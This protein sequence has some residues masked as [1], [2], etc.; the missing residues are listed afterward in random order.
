ML[1]LPL[2]HDLYFILQLLLCG[3]PLCLNAFNDL[4]KIL[5]YQLQ[6]EIL[7]LLYPLHLLI[8]RSFILVTELHFV[9]NLLLHAGDELLNLVDLFL[10]CE[11]GGGLVRI[12]RQAE[13]PRH[14]FLHYFGLPA[15]QAV[16][17]CFVLLFIN[18]TGSNRRLFCLLDSLL[19]SSRGLL[20]TISLLALSLLLTHLQLIHIAVRF[21]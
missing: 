21:V 13:R 6:L 14:H 16:M 3:I 8:Q 5:C 1:L 17:A 12:T 2:F 19:I 18:V 15:V 11:R 10:L 20:R 7:M 4:A 9:F